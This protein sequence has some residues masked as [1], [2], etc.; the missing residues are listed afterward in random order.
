M[1]VS[2]GSLGTVHPSQNSHG[3]RT[4][5]MVIYLLLSIIVSQDPGV[6]SGKK[7]VDWPDRGRYSAQDDAIAKLQPKPIVNKKGLFAPAHVKINHKNM[8]EFSRCCLNYTPWME[9]ANMKRGDV[10]RILISESSNKYETHAVVKQV[11]N[12][13][14]CIVS[15]RK[16]SVWISNIDTTDFAEGHAFLLDN[17][18]E[19]AGA[20]T[21]TTVL[22]SNKSISHIK[23]SATTELFDV[24][25][26]TLVDDPPKKSELAFKPWK[27]KD[28]GTVLGLLT[29]V[30]KEDVSMALP[31]GATNTYKMKQLESRD[32]AYSRK[33]KSKLKQ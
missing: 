23:Y 33:M 9:L 29:K 8:I 14:E 32:R 28:E 15:V 19:C 4:R 18:F 25:Q 6:L 5:Y 11:V 2:G 13:R 27:I 10:G 7:T 3:I 21:Y 26:K 22:G 30:T 16:K 1:L 31:N 12:D 24:L 17:V 20:K